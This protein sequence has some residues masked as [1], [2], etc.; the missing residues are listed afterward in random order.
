MELNKTQDF[1]RYLEQYFN[2]QYSSPGNSTMTDRRNF[3]IYEPYLNQQQRS[4]GTFN[5]N[6]GQNDSVG[7]I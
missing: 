5:G 4:E 7:F 6:Q 3:K 1:Y 2:Q